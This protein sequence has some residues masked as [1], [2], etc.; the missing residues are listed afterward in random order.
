MRLTLLDIALVCFA[1]IVI[2]GGVYWSYRTGESVQANAPREQARD[3]GKTLVNSIGMRLTLIPA[4][5]FKM[6]SPVTEVYR[7]EDEWQHEVVITKPFY[8]GVYE[9][10]QGEYE[11]TLHSNRSFFSAKGAGRARVEKKD[12]SEHPAERVTWDEAVEFC[13]KL[14]AKEGKTYRLPTEAEWEYACRAG[15]KT[16]F[17]MG[18]K[19]NSEMGN[20]N[21][22]RY[23]SYGEEFN[24]PFHRSTVRVGEYRDHANSFGLFDMHGNVQEWCADWYAGDYYQQSPKDDPR[25]PDNGTERVLRGGAWPSSA[26]ACRAAAR[27]RLAPDERTWTNGFRVV[28][29]AK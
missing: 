17:H 5:K 3:D 6:G 28:L 1:T 18:D 11:K 20:I 26:K 22:L 25:G 7:N 24:G 27:N 29:E 10:T 19:F 21:G 8:L 14:S 2:G 16:V 13:K 15:A 4:G 12:T 23:S 9:V